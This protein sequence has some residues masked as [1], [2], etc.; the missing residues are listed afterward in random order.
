[1]EEVSQ[2]RLS[3][4]KNMT[5]RS[6]RRSG[7]CFVTLTIVFGVALAGVFI[8]LSSRNTRQESDS[9]ILLH[10]VQRGDFEAFVT[11][12]GDV[13]SSSNVMDPIEALRRE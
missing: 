5:Q 8:I 2:H 4:T 3:P 11:E 6:H 12:P 1:M 10:E 13:V 7:R 9:T